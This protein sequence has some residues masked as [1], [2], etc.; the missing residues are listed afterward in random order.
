M[1]A[2]LFLML[3]L[4]L[5][6]VRGAVAACMGGPEPRSDACGAMCC[7]LCAAAE[8]CPCDAGPQQPAPD[9]EP[10]APIH[11]SEMAR[12]VPAPECI[13]LVGVVPGVSPRGPPASSL[14]SIDSTVG[15]FLSRVCVWTT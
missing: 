12:I 5:H 13:V 8:T 9:P 6:P 10:I 1:P 4:L 3:I 14:R 15:R 7:P 11:P 2:R